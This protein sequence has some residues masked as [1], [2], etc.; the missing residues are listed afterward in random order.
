MAPALAP[1]AITDTG[2]GF[3]L[4]SD[5]PTSRA[6]DRIKLDLSFETAA[7]RMAAQTLPP[8]HTR[9]S[10]P[11]RLLVSPLERQAQGQAHLLGVPA[12]FLWH[13]PKPD[14]K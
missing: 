4:N 12:M 7:A 2:G 14:V 6:D 3:R 11:Y 10:V 9:T 8:M 5:I 1:K 13:I